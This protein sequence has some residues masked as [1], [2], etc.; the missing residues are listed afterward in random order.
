MIWQSLARLR[1]VVKTDKRLRNAIVRCQS[2]KKKHKRRKPKEREGM[3]L[4][5]LARHA[6]EGVVKGFFWSIG[7]TIG[8][9]VVTSLLVFVLSRAEALPFIGQAIASVVQATLESLGT[10]VP[11]N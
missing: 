10:G 7:V 1:D 11:G 3:T 5:E 2:T 6:K 4:K 8:F 9:A